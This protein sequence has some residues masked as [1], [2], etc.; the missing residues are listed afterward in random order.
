MQAIALQ[1]GWEN[2][3]GIFFQVHLSTQGN[4]AWGNLLEM[5]C[6]LQEYDLQGSGDWAWR[7]FYEKGTPYSS[8]RTWRPLKAQIAMQVKEKAKDDVKL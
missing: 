5:Q 8:R 4:Q 3:N 7:H 2:E 1:T 6:T